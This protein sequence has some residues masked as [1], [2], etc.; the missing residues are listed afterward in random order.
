VKGLRTSVADS[1]YTACGPLTERRDLGC[2][3]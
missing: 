2:R 3:S 1:G